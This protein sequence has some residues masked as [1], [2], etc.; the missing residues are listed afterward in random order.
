MH[1]SPPD[2]SELDILARTLW[3]EAR[4]EGY[5]GMLAVAHV[6]AN[7]VF[8]HRWPNSFAEV[9]KQPQQFSCWN[10]EGEASQVKR[11]EQLTFE[12][13]RNTGVFAVAAEVALLTGRS[14][15][16]TFGANHYLTNQLM[17]NK[18]KAPTWADPRRITVV[19]K[20]HTFL[21]I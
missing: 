15:D 6:V 14:V 9:C 20:N 17:W 13:L 10:P 4:G 5:L 3:G 7:R 19:I 1:D 8:D 18:E 12:H 16:P 2:I 21:A 11:M